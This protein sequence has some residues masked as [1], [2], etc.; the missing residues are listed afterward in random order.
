MDIRMNQMASLLYGV[1]EKQNSNN[2]ELMGEMTNL[3][4]EKLHNHL[5]DKF[6]DIAETMHR[7]DSS[8]GDIASTQ[9][10][11]HQEM[12]GLM[13]ELLDEKLSI[14]LEDRVA[15]IGDTLSQINSSIGS[16]VVKEDSNNQELMVKMSEILQEKVSN[17][18]EDNLS[19]IGDTMHQLNY[20]IEGIV[21]N[22]GET[23]YQIN[24]T[25]GGTVDKRITNNNQ[26]MVVNLSMIIEE[27]VSSYVEDT[28]FKI[29]FTISGFIAKQDLNNEEIVG[30]F[31]KLLTEKL[32]NHEEIR[33]NCSCLEVKQ[34]NYIQNNLS[35]IKN[36]MKQM[37]STLED[38]EG[39]FASINKITKKIEH[40]L[41]AFENKSSQS[42]ILQKENHQELEN[43][44]MNAASM[45]DNVIEAL[46][47]KLLWL[48]NDSV[49]LGPV[50]G[51]LNTSTMDENMNASE[52]ILLNSIK[53]NNT[54]INIP[55]LAVIRLESHSFTPIS[56]IQIPCEIE[57][58]EPITVTWFKGENNRLTT[59]SEKYQV[60]SNNTLIIKN[61]QESDSDNYTCQVQNRY[62]TASSTAAIEIEGIYVHPSCTDNRF[63][64]NCKLIVRAEYC[65][66]TYYA[67]FCCRSCT[68]AGQLPSH[69]PHLQQSGRGSRR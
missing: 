12:V 66:S 2:Q 49:P 67:N 23:L 55:L 42:L 51:P 46:N 21:A 68:L 27:Q 11:T 3:L 33:G 13:S 65:I 15:G 38:V 54:D 8:M 32:S 20:S 4:Q 60:T 39:K 24:S 28:L 62:T 14:Y 43:M 17:H 63:F 10:S 9:D 34:S 45:D 35:D 1:T 37:Q 50:E 22:I 36:T 5:E 58:D 30:N 69:G 52:S 44:M 29:N 26:N 61:A 56:T 31:S 40:E 57:G 48:K 6:S 53:P 16:M 41:I 59:Q 47:R 19:A 64:A 7:L 18:L 25:I